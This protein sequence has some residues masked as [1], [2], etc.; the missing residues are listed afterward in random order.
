MTTWQR[1]GCECETAVTTAE[2]ENQLRA[3]RLSRHVPAVAIDWIRDEPERRWRVLDGSLCFADI[4]GFTALTERLE[5]RGPIGA[6]EL[7]DTL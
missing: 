4:S 1:A 7:V 2:V 3:D 6:E 5:A